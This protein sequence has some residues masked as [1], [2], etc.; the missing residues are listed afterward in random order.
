MAST[1][2]SS[3]DI[4]SKYLEY[5]SSLDLFN[6]ESETLSFGTLKRMNSRQLMSRLRHSY[7]SNPTDSCHLP[8]DALFIDNFCEEF[9][10]IYKMPH[11]FVDLPKYGCTLTA[12][13]K[14]SITFL[15]YGGKCV[16]AR[17]I[18]LSEK[19]SLVLWERPFC[20]HAQTVSDMNYGDRWEG[21]DLVYEGNKYGDTSRFYIIGYIDKHRI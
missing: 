11:E 6:I 12:L 14:T 4:L 18:P 9:I 2:I 15:R 17:N 13:K 19:S 5:I 20:L 16:E 10:V 8:I 7:G 1:N 3:T 21:R